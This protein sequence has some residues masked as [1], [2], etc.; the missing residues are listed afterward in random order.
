MEATGGNIGQQCL[1][2]LVLL[3]LLS[4]SR[5]GSVVDSS[6][7]AALYNTVQ[8]LDASIVNTAVLL[9]KQHRVLQTVRRGLVAG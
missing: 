4:A 3:L 7:V 1:F 9:N 6:E 2:D 5:R 8:L